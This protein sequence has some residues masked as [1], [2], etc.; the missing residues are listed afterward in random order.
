[1]WPRKNISKSWQ[2]SIGK[3]SEKRVYDLETPIVSFIK[4]GK[5]FNISKSMVINKA[6]FDKNFQVFTDYRT[7]QGQK[8]KE[9]S[10]GMIDMAW[11]G[12]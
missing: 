9:D 5:K 2:K 12:P 10:R 3:Y 4:I 8:I 6:F 1:L 7:V 11:R